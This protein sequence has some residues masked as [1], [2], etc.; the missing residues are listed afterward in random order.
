MVRGDLLL[1]NNF[2]FDGIIVVFGSVNIEQF[3]RIY[4]G[5][6]QVPGLTATFNLTNHSRVQYS[7]EVMEMIQATIPAE[8]DSLGGWQEISRN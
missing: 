5:L 8:N 2:R 4:G 1:R 7:Y 6:V 3:L